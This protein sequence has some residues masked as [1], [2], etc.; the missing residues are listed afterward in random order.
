MKSAVLIRL[1][2]GETFPCIVKYTFKDEFVGDFVE[3]DRNYA[4]VNYEEPDEAQWQIE[5]LDQFCEHIDAC[6]SRVMEF[7]VPDIEGAIG[8]VQS[9][10][11]LLEDVVILHEGQMYCL[12]EI[13]EQE[14]RSKR[15][16]RKAR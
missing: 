13:T 4:F 6:H 7:H 8:L 16:N 11:D 5:T 3:D 10:E 9:V 15:R 1:A 14:T 12:S 2:F